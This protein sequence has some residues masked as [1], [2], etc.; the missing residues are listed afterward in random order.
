MVL[1]LLLSACDNSDPVQ[2]STQ[3]EVLPGKPTLN[4]DE[5]NKAE[6][7]TY[8]VLGC[9]NTFRSQS[10]DP[11]IECMQKGEGMS[12]VSAEISILHQSS[13]TVFPKCWSCKAK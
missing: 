9:G 11:A 4:E 2:K 7:T 10:V 3:D 1:F 8:E 5:Q 6:E 13:I 12:L